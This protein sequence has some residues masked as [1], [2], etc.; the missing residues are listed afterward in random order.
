MRYP[1][2]GC[3]MVELCENPSTAVYTT[4]AS[5]P[6]RILG[7]EDFLHYTSNMASQEPKYTCKMCG[8]GFCRPVI[9]YT[10]GGDMLET[11]PKCGAMI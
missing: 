7:C 11:C 1:C 2:D 6:M 5:P 10:E 8:N 3:K 4:I 9:N